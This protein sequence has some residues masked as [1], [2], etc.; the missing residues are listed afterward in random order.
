MLRFQISLI[1]G[2]ISFPLNI[3]GISGSV[4]SKN[5]VGRLLEIARLVY[6]GFKKLTCQYP[7]IVSILLKPLNLVSLFLFVVLEKVWRFGCAGTEGALV[8]GMVM[9]DSSLL[10]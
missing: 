1:L 4:R 10:E 5:G 9:Q 6:L 8:L 7:V 2:G 3:I